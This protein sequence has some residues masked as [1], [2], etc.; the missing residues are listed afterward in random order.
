MTH[1]VAGLCTGHWLTTGLL[2]EKSSSVTALAPSP[3]WEESLLLSRAWRFLRTGC[4]CLLVTRAGQTLCWLMDCWEIA[5]GILKH[6]YH[7]P[8]I[9]ESCHHHQRHCMKLQNPNNKTQQS[10]GVFVF[11]INKQISVFTGP[12]TVNLV[13]HQQYSPGALLI[14]P[15]PA[16]PP[17]VL[18]RSPA[19]QG[20][21]P[22]GALVDVFRLPGEGPGGG[23]RPALYV[24]DWRRSSV[25]GYP[26]LVQPQL[27]SPPHPGGL[28]E[29]V[30]ITGV[31]NMR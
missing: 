24:G 29:G 12:G 28:G 13:N 21:L 7:S 18:R 10:I 17:G 25:L 11:Q 22:H 5:R 27:C 19:V 20:T 23:E 14:P 4:G 1:L 8:V 31:V 6:C 2:L 3:T 30:D 15:H 26:Q 16:L 9:T